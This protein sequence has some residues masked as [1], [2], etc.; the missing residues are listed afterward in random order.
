LIEEALEVYHASKLD[1]ANLMAIPISNVG[2]A[3]ASANGAKNP[4]PEW[5]NPFQKI[6]DK[7]NQN[8]CQTT[9]RM[10]KELLSQN[11]IPTWVFN[12]VDVDSLR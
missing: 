7:D 2:I 1:Q 5:F 10:W 11:K 4:S 12:L 8:Y 9:I 3:I 6:V